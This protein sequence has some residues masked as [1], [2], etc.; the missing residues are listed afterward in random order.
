MSLSCNILPAHSQQN[1]SFGNDIVKATNNNTSTF[2]LPLN[3]LIPERVSASFSPPKGTEIIE[4]VGNDKTVVMRL[5]NSKG[6]AIL[7]LVIE[8]NTG[9]TLEGLKKIP[10]QISVEPSYEHDE[11][12]GSYKMYEFQGINDSKPDEPLAVT[13]RVYFG[14]RDSFSTSISSLSIKGFSEEQIKK[15]H[16][17]QKAL[18]DNS[19]KIIKHKDNY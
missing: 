9:A 8:I 5:P 11:S 16:Q 12:F 10:E 14:P 18:L 17:E 1:A 19:I 15:I 3:H 7:A 6:A 2:L 4:G 13:F